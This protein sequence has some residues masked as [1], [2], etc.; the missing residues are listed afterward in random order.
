MI[1]DRSSWIA[2]ELSELERESLKRSLH[3]VE[4]RDKAQITVENKPLLNF[5]SNDYLG[6]CHHPRVLE[7]VQ[8]VLGHWGAGATASR[9]ISGTTIIHR[10]LELAL[11]AFLGQ[12]ACLLFPAGY[13]AN[14]GVLTSL[15]GSGDAIVMDRLCHASLI[16]GARLSGARLFVYRHADADDAEKVL[17]RASSHRRRLLVTESLFSMDGDFA[18]LADLRAAAQRQ[19]AMSLVDE[20]HAIGVWGETGQG[21]S[22]EFNLTEKFDIVIGTLS[23]SLGSQGGFVCGSSEVMELLVNKARS[24]IYTTGLSPACIG[25]A[26]A[27]LSLLQEE[28]QRR[29]RVRELSARL[30]DGL[31]AKGWDCLNSVSQIVPVWS[32]STENA[33]ALAKCLRE[34]GIYAPAIRPPTV[35]RDECRLRFS[36]T[37]DHGSEDVDKLLSAMDKFPLPRS[38]G[39][40]V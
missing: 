33:L 15:A 8:E 24:F 2:E 20:A 1:V 22:S 14:V 4:L 9:L 25:A 35:S 40:G 6:L 36:I 27:A 10:D 28:S 32:G 37:A 19:G 18:P 31:K 34:A 5:S 12:E 16:D 11:A 13:M 39:E 29:R 23:K 7:A 21:A 17:K 30:R 3:S 38:A 26:Q